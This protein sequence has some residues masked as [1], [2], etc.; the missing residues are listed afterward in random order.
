MMSTKLRGW[1]QFV[2]L[3]GVGL[4]LLWLAFRGQDLGAIWA[5]MGQARWEWVGVGLGLTLLGHL[6]RARRWQL[7]IRAAGHE[8]GLWACFMTMMTGYLSNLG[9]PRIG[10]MN[11]CVALNRLSGAPVLA[12]GGTVVAERAVDLA[13]FALLLLV[14]IFMMGAQAGAFFFQHLFVPLGAVLNWKLVFV[15]CMAV[16]LLLGLYLLAFNPKRVAG[17]GLAD[18]ASAW[19]KEVWSGLVA[20]LRMRGAALGAFGLHTVLIWLSYYAAPFCTLLALG[21]VTDD[22]WGLAFYVFVFGSLSRTIPL[23]AGSAGAYHYIVSQ[24][25]MFLGYAQVEGMSVATLNHAVQT[26]FYL[27][28]G[29]LGLLGFF[30]LLRF[31]SVGQSQPMANSKTPKL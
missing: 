10:E 24:W 12:L 15:A 23:P 7:L 11:R 22:L 26:L 31:R 28:F 27:V 8:A 1:L 16:L 18:R 29:A 20:A 5:E 9:I 25:M 30:V 6:S 17:S 14:T 2:G 13:T 4:L 19:A 21:I 3:L